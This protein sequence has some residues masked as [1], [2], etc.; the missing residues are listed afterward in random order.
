MRRTALIAASCLGLTLAGTAASV[1]EPLRLNVRP[2]SWLDAGNVV[3]PGSSVNPASARGQ[4]V[5][6]YLSPPWHNMRDR[7]GEGTLPDP[8]GGPFV[9]ARN[10]LGPVDF[11]APFADY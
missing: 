3:Q 10:E 5:S 7:F 6:Y 8:F 4:M 2:R 9:G 11:G 1:A